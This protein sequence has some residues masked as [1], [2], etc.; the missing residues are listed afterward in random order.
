MFGLISI[1]PHVITDRYHPGVCSLV[2][3]TKLT[4]TKYKA[5]TVKMTGLWRMQKYNKEEIVAMN[6]KVMCE[7][8]CLLNME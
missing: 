7:R 5:E 6:E 4:V 1:A 2:H 8:L 3:G